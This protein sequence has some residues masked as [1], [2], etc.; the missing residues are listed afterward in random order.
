MKLLDAV[1]LILPKL[2]EH[3]VTSVTL[4]HPTL[5][6]ILPEVDNEL[7]R[8]CNQGWWF[9]QF[10]Y[11]AT[12]DVDGKIALGTDTLSFVP[13]VAYA[14]VRGK[15]LYNVE[16]MSYVW[17]DPVEGLLTTYVQF[18][19]LPE[20][21]AQVVWWNALINAFATDIGVS[22]ELQIWQVRAGAAASDLMAEHLRNRRYNT[23]KTKRFRRLRNALRG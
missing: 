11:K 8:V 20:T 12:P 3:P 14:A 22:Q 15:E 21:A 9:N 16:T 18:E 13:Y 2:G 19:E 23:K 17:D 7:K 4:K 6:I 1:N 5:A 10:E